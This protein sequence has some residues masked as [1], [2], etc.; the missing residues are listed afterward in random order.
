MTL[1]GKRRR[2]TVDVR[3]DWGPV[4]GDIRHDDVALGRYGALSTL[5]VLRESTL[6]H[7]GNTLGFQTSRLHP[8]DEKLEDCRMKGYIESCRM[9]V[10]GWP[11]W[12]AR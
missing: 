11:G 4:A 6:G 3:G 10:A 1:G 8:W 7:N 12:N 5:P 9:T 2:D